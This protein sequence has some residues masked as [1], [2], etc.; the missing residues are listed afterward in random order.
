MDVAALVADLIRDEDLRLKPYRCTEGKLTIGVGRNLDDVG[1]SRAEALF[2]LDNDIGNTLAELD[3]RIPWWRSLSE[4]RQRAQAN[5][6]F[7]MGLPRLLGFKNML[8][9]LQG[10]DYETA[11]AE[12]LNSKWAKQVGIRADRIAELFK[13]G[14]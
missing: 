2:L 13:T 8:A 3:R 9:A 4:P 6:A 5:M 14:G 10:G 12:A 11:A 7:N 1:I